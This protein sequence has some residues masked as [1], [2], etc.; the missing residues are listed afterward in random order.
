MREFIF[1]ALF[2]CFSACSLFA[3]ESDIQRR[4]QAET[5]P[6]PEFPE[7]VEKLYLDYGAW[8]RWDGVHFD[9]FGADLKK[10]SVRLEYFYAWTEAVLNETHRIY[11]RAAAINLDYSRGDSYRGDDDRFYSPRLDLGFYEFRTQRGAKTP[12]APSAFSLRIGRQYLRVGT[13]LAYNRVHDALLAKAQLRFLMLDA[14]WS[15]SVRSEDDIDRSRPDLSHSHRDFYGLTAK[16]KVT[17]ACEPY[18]FAV[19]QRDRNGEHPYAPSADFIFDSEYYGVGSTGSIAKRLNYSVE[20]IWER[21][22]RCPDQS[23]GIPLRPEPITANAAAVKLEYLPSVECRPI[24]AAEYLYASGDKDRYNATDTMFGNTPGT[25]DRAF[26]GFGFVDAGYV[27]Y[28]ILTNLHIYKLSG[29]IVLSQEKEFCR[30]LRTGAALIWFSRDKREGA[31]SDTRADW[32]TT[33]RGGVGFEFDLFATYR[34]FSDLSV[35]LRYGHFEPGSA[36][37]NLDHYRDP[38]DYFSFFLLYSF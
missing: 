1:A 2:V 3:Q 31:I 32:G 10:R 11:L 9:D 7:T 14:F 28:P 20:W 38:R 30:E 18:A 6:A 35:T 5:A 15:T 24:V 37:P 17:S 22:R 12:S 13:G 25:L 16:V 26:L 29:S 36:Y 19:V 21:G 4:I 8:L 27:L 33:G 34:I 23:G